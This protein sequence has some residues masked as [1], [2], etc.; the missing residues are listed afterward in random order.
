M[1]K[2]NKNDL[3]KLIFIDKLPYDTIGLKYNVSG[4]A[5]RKAAKKLGIELPAR[6]KINSN[7]TFNKGTAEIKY[8]LNC[9]KQLS[10]SRSKCCCATC[11]QE[12]QRKEWIKSWKEGKKSGIVSECSVSFYIKKYLFDKYDNKC[13]ICG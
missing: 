6:R 11:W 10:N 1:E 4:S 3:E 12:F 13:A 2:Y 5:I 7:E 8:C 9:G